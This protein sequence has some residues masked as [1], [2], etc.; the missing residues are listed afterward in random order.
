M[1]GDTNSHCSSVS[2]C[3]FIFTDLPVVREINRQN[4][5]F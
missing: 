4:H 1:R 2:S 5:E 3:R